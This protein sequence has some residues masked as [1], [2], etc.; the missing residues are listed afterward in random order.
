VNWKQFLDYRS[1]EGRTRRFAA[2]RVIPA[3]TST[4]YTTLWPRLHALTPEVQLPKYTD[5]EVRSDGTGL[6]TTN[7]GEH[8]TFRNGDPDASLRKRLVVVITMDVRRKKLIGG[9]VH[10]EGKGHSEPGTAAAHVKG[11]TEQGYPVRKFYGDWAFD[12]YRLFTTR[13]ELGTEPVVEIARNVTSHFRDS[14]RSGGAPRGRAVREYRRLGYRAWAGTK[15]YGM[16]WPGTEEIISAMKR[17]FGE[18][19]VS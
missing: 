2:L 14:H 19:S 5:L 6:R 18:D 3:S 4:D 12:S 13:G 9:E 16:R 1:L 15:G 11:A 7:A 17:K 8:R 10:I